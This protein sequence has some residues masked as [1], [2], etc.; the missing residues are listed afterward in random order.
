MLDGLGR[1]VLVRRGSRTV[2]DNG[3]PRDFAQIAISEGAKVHPPVPAIGFFYMDRRTV[4]S[5]VVN[6][7]R[8]T[9]TA[10]AAGHSS[11]GGA[12]AGRG[13]CPP[14]RAP[15]MGTPW[16]TLGHRDAWLSREWVWPRCSPGAPCFPD[17]QLPN[18]APPTS[19]NIR[20][21][22]VLAPLCWAVLSTPVLRSEGGLCS[23]TSYSACLPTKIPKSN[24]LAGDHH[25]RP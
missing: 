13:R 25:H 17:S 9:S 11:R 12:V 3:W 10:A 6:G 19:A 18:Q 22:G 23:A 8:W 15:P 2:D 16:F 24:P 1:D 21:G 5:G 4:L 7:A 14:Q 20:Q